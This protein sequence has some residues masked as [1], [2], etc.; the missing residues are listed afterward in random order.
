MKTLMC[1]LWL[2]AGAWKKFQS[3]TNRNRACSAPVLSSSSWSPCFCYISLLTLSAIVKL[4]VCNLRIIRMQNWCNG[5]Y[6]PTAHV[7]L[8]WIEFQRTFFAITLPSQLNTFYHPA[9]R[10]TCSLPGTA[11]IRVKLDV[12]YRQKKTAT[13]FKS[14]IIRGCVCLRSFQLIPITAVLKNWRFYTGTLPE[15]NLPVAKYR[16]AENRP[17]SACPWNISIFSIKVLQPIVCITQ[18][19]PYLL[20]YRAVLPTQSARQ[21]TY[22]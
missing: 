18:N 21:V 17:C 6:I 12:I 9:P 22:E 5:L 4:L 10:V 14:D 16:P 13:E 19:T 20:Y 7:T 1:L 8:S 3:L 15:R 2:A 11:F